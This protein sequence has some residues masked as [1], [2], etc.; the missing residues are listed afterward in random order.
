MIFPI[1]STK[2]LHHYLEINESRNGQT[3]LPPGFGGAAIGAAD[4][5]YSSGVFGFEGFAN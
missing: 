3:L 2:L 4:S 1:Q 5:D